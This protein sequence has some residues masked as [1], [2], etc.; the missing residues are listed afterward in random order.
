MES[1]ERMGFSWRKRWHSLATQNTNETICSPGP[2][3]L[4]LTVLR[5]EGRTCSWVCNELQMWVL[6]DPR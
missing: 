1:G 6:G 4:P 3:Q 5:G 2:S